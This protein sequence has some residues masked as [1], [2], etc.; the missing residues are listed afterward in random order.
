MLYISK[1]NI[2]HIFN[3]SCDTE[4]MICLP[5]SNSSVQ[6]SAYTCLCNLGYYVP[7]QTYQ[8]FEGHLIESGSGNYTC[9]R[10]PNGCACDENGKC[11][12]GDLQE[13]VLIE[14][15]LLHFSIGAVLGA[16]MLCVLVLF[17]IVFRQRKSKVDVMNIIN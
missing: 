10:C 9:I 8:G 3:V 13:L 17:A 7:N 2:N 6:R 5:A 12:M 14:E 1:T 16:C 15:T 11:S 4:T